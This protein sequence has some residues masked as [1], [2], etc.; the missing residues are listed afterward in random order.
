MTTTNVEVFP[1]RA[2]AMFL[3]L[4]PFFLKG[5]QLSCFLRVFSTENIP[6]LITSVVSKRQTFGFIFNQGNREGQDVARH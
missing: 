6:A 4:R 1:L 3:A 5:S 2:F